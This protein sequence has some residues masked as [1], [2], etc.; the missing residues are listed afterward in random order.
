MEEI[1]RLELL[2]K[3]S[4]NIKE[5]LKNE[6]REYR[7][8]FILELFKKEIKNNNNLSLIISS[9]QIQR[10]EDLTGDYFLSFSNNNIKEEDL[11]SLF[12]KQVEILKKA[13]E[14]E[15]EILSLKLNNLDKYIEILK[16]SKKD[17]PL[18]TYFK[19]NDN[20]SIINSFGEDVTNDEIDKDYIEYALKYIINFIKESKIYNL[21]NLKYHNIYLDKINKDK[22]N[23][24]LYNEDF[25]I[26]Q[27]EILTYQKVIFPDI[28]EIKNYYLDTKEKKYFYND[29]KETYLNKEDWIKI[30]APIITTLSHI[31]DVL[32]I[33][34]KI[35]SEFYDEDYANELKNQLKLLNEADNNYV[36][37]DRYW[38]LKDSTN[39]KYLEDLIIEMLIDNY[40]FNKEEI[41][42]IRNISVSM[43]IEFSNYKD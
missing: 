13:I 21:E 24:E 32:D 3:D 15:K 7:N 10:Y 39:L 8:S 17:S 12:N 18:S 37:D 20:I 26:S 35:A 29:F 42:K 25:F 14:I 22:K 31:K 23:I 6:Y 43:K 27:A 34:E 19:E 40:N 38:Y 28:L 9:P 33:E 30:L 16:E 4:F 41:T 11:I 2:L 5:Q 1:K 36:I